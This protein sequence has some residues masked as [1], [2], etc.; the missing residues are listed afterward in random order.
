[1]TPAE[2][3]LREHCAG[4]PPRLLDCMV[5]ALPGTPTSVPDAMVQG[6]VRLYR[7]VT[8]SDCTREDAL[9]LLAADALLTHAFQVQAELDVSGVGALAD[10]CGAVGLLGGI[11]QEERDW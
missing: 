2:L 1:V 6:A 4:A 7:E 9:P 11:A 5:H 3:W 10:R 8:T